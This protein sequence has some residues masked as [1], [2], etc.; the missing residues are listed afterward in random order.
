MKNCNIAIAA[1]LIIALNSFC[2]AQ[3]KEKIEPLEEKKEIT[4]TKETKEFSLKVGEEFT[5]EFLANPSTGFCWGMLVNQAPH[6]RWIELIKSEYVP[7]EPIRPGSG[8]THK[9][10]F[11][12]MRP[13]GTIKYSIPFYHCRPT[14][15]EIATV[16]NIVFSIK[17]GEKER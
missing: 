12:A 1:V 2:T 15:G 9:F 5:L 13:T 7:D 3:T 14:T 17:N 6:E 10:T 11:K 16:V 8:G 4:P